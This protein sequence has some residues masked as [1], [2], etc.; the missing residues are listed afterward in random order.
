MPWYMPL[1]MA[2]SCTRP[3]PVKLMSSPQPAG[4]IVDQDAFA[5]VG[6]GG[7]SA[8]GESAAFN[9]VDAGVEGHVGVAAD[10]DAADID[11][12]AED[13]RGIAA[14]LQR[15]GCCGRSGP[16]CWGR[17]ARQADRVP[18]ACL[19]W[20]GPLIEPWPLVELPPTMSN[21]RG[22]DRG[23]AGNEHR[24]GIRGIHGDRAAGDAAWHCR[25]RSA[26]PLLTSVQ[27]NDAAAAGGGVTVM[28]AEVL[29]APP[30]LSVA[31]SVTVKTP[32]SLARRRRT[33]PSRWRSWWSCRSWCCV[34]SQANVKPAAV[35]AGEGSV[36]E[37]VREIACADDWPRRRRR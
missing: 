26:A 5:Q 21:S 28:L 24:G 33:A 32:S 2:D 3:L 11:A 34:T 17:Q 13:H 23:V 18:A 16:R 31:V 29:E 20:T 4:V 9:V 19:L 37:P 22:G 1:V 15:R 25:W 36:A 10:V 27:E 35:S 30:S 14:D 6:E 8:D 7:V 12:G